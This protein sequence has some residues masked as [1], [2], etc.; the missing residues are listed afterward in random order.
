MEDKAWRKRSSN[1]EIDSGESVVKDKYSSQ[2]SG[3][4][5]SGVDS[6]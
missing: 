3:S 4:R 5:K 6:E 1:R 2:E